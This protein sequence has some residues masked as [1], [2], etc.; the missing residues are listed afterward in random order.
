M[1]SLLKT[2]APFFLS[3]AV[4]AGGLYAYSQRA[5][6]PVQQS[7]SFGAFTPVGGSTYV[8]SGSGVVSTATTIPVTAFKTPDGR[9]LTMAMF[10]TIGYAVLDPNSPS[11]IEDITFTGIT[12]NANGSAILTGVSRGMDFVT[13]YSASSTLAQ[14]HAGGSYL[15]L[16]NTAGFYGQ[17][18]LFSNSNSSSTA[19][20]T[21]SPTTPPAYYPSVGQQAAGT[22]NSTTSELASIAYVNGVVASGAPNATT[23]VK[24][25]VQL[26]SA[27]QAAAGTALGSTGASLL[28][29]NSLFNATQSATTI[30]PV[31]NTS[32]KLSQLF[33]DLTQSFTFLGALSAPTSTIGTLNVGN[34]FASST[35]TI[36]NL[37]VTG[38]VS[39]NV[40]S[41]KLLTSTTTS[42][43]MP[44]ATTTFA[45][46]SDLHIIIY[47]PSMTATSI[48]PQFNSDGS[49]SYADNTF[50]N[51][52]T[53]QFGGTNNARNLIQLLE[54]NVATTTDMYFTIDIKNTASK[55]KIL[56]WNGT[57]SDS[58]NHFGAVIQGTGVWNNTSAQI[59]TMALISNNNACGSTNIPQGAIINVYGQ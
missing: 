12:Q 20:M 29:P 5:H 49:I 53:T 51:Y 40:G 50:Y 3:L 1:K 33:L 45:A 16:S 8:L 30:I 57:E 19:F 47:I 7:Q 34:L 9:A 48:C 6:V 23:L 24:G 28:P 55:R 27:V 56:T 10:G 42:Q 46:A 43:I 35:A 26:A 14:A 15:I 4:I 36:T 38:T 52:S 18:F 25:I 22:Y 54:N 39:G 31:T 17:Q 11:K 41:W 21:F 13:P 2:I 32:G 44:N 58:G 59:T 37:N